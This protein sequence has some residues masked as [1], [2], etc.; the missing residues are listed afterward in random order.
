MTAKLTH[1]PDCGC[2]LAPRDDAGIPVV[3]Q[4]ADG[5]EVAA[6]AAELVAGMEKFDL[7]SVVGKA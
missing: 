2:E 4:H 3:A 6:K 1:C 5:C 7:S